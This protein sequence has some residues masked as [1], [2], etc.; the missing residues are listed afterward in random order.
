MAEAMRARQETMK[1]SEQLQTKAMRDLQRL[2]KAVVYQRTVLRVQFVDH[3]ILQGVFHP[4]EKVA[5][6]QEWVR[7]CLCEEAQ[8]VPFFLFTSPPMCALDPKATL[9]SCK[10]VPAARI[11]LSWGDKETRAKGKTPIVEGYLA[12]AWVVALEDGPA[13]LSAT[14]ALPSAIPLVAAPPAA[15]AAPAPAAPAAPGGKRPGGGAF[16]WLK[17]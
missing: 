5:A 17:L 13:D 4:D 6:V 16:K 3:V 10:L 8:E 7:S 2:Q 14:T 15:P 1:Q 11:Y 12:P 9:S